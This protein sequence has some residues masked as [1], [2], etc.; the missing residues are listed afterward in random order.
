[1]MYQPAS[2]YRSQSVTKHPPYGLYLDPHRGQHNWT[3][4]SSRVL[5]G[6]VTLIGAIFIVVALGP[7]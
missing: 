3:A 5:L 7:H 4:A 2:I 6:L 1:M